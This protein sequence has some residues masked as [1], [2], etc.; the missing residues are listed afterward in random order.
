MEIQIRNSKSIRDV[1][2]EF[3]QEFPFLKP[4]FFSKKHGAFKGSHSKFLISKTATTLGEIRDS[5]GEGRLILEDDMPVWQVERMFEEEFG[6]HVQIFRKSGGKWLETTVTDDLDL[7]AQNAKGRASEEL[8]LPI[9]DP[10][11]YREQ[12]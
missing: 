4:M 7:E 11:D 3:Q 9:V 8:V 12:Y 5:D 10:L 2:Q 6:L 1:Q